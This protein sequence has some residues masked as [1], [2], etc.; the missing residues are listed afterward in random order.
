MR[1]FFVVIFTFLLFD[2]VSAQDPHFSQFYASPLTL[3]PAFTG[4]FDGDYR[5]AANYR[6][7]WASIPN[8]YTTASASLD[9][10]ILKKSLPKGDIFGLG[11][12][13]VSDQSADGA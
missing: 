8:A 11:F 7:Q 13:G 3:N 12:S 9:F 5:L 6:N 4:K 10:G 1:K 2:Y